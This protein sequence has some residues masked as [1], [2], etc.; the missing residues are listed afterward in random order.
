MDFRIEYIDTDG[1]QTSKIL[2]VDSVQE[3]A[4]V[5]AKKGITPY[6]ISTCLQPQP[7]QRYLVVFCC[8]SGVFDKLSSEEQ[9]RVMKEVAEECD[10]ATPHEF[11]VKGQPWVLWHRW[12]IEDEPNHG[13]YLMGISTW[14]D[15][16]VPCMEAVG[17]CLGADDFAIYG[18]ATIQAPIMYT[19]KF[20][21][22]PAHIAYRS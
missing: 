10:R 16:L 2:H 5:A 13:V 9:A 22:K 3:A 12:A 1:L 19:Y 7:T 20:I 15:G 17:N 11:A 18:G 14:V 6:N 21:R 8:E 4:Q